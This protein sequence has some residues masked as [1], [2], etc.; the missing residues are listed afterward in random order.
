MKAI[1][2][3]LILN[4]VLRFLTIMLIKLTLVIIYQRLLKIR[5]EFLLL[6]RARPSNSF[7]G[8]KSVRKQ[9]KHQVHVLMKMIKPLSK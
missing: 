3:Q 5:R 1:E 6:V 4:Q 9:K 7:F 2:K 8:K